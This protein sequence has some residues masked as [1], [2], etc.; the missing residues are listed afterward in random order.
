MNNDSIIKKLEVYNNARP[1]AATSE[2]LVLKK[3]EKNHRI[4]YLSI[5]SWY[6]QDKAGIE[7]FLLLNRTGNRALLNP[8]TNPNDAIEILDAALDYLSMLMYFL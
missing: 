6:Q 1:G 2:L 4:R 5:N 7:F 3:L 8:K